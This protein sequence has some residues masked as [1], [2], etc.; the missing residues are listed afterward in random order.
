MSGKKK[1]LTEAEVRAKSVG[2]IQ[3]ITDNSFSVTTN[4]GIV[5]KCNPSDKKYKVY[6]V[7]SKVEHILYVGY[8]ALTLE[9]RTLCR[10]NEIRRKITKNKKLSPLL[11]AIVTHGSDNFLM[12]E[13]CGFD[14]KDDALDCERRLI[15][16]YQSHVSNGGYNGSSGGEGGLSGATSEEL[17]RESNAATLEIIKWILKHDGVSPNEK[18]KDPVEKKLGEKLHSL[19]TAF[20]NSDNTTHAR[21]DSN[22]E[23]AIKHGLYWLF[24]SPEELANDDMH[25]IINWM[26]EHDGVPPNKE[27]DDPVERKYGEKLNHFKQARNN[28]KS[29]HDCYNVEQIAIDRGFPH[30]LYSPEERRNVKIREF[31]HFVKE[32]NRTPKRS[33]EKEKK[34]SKWWK[35]TKAAIKK[36]TKQWTASNKKLAEELGVAEYFENSPSST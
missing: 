2:L 24:F 25:E 18:S 29:S 36:G 35:N 31:A 28:T 33:I 34:L 12:F 8:T 27:S 32:N 5:V 15:K 11:T 30:L 4:N 16:E 20:N 3:V 6:A 7:V 22:R 17:E 14:N 13:L 10:Q 23:L 21:Y 1:Q 19:R 9:K 26:L